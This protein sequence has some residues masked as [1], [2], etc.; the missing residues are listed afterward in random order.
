MRLF[1]MNIGNVKVDTLIA[2]GNLF[3]ICHYD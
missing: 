1:A 2:Y 3:F